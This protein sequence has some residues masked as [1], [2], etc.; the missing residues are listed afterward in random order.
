MKQKTS[1]VFR[2]TFNVN[3]LLL[4]TGKMLNFSYR[5]SFSTYLPS[6]LKMIVTEV[7]VTE[8]NKD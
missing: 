6:M 8:I 7:I 2:N 3:T 1:R 4:D 5:V